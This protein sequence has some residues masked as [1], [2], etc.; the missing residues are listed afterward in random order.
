MLFSI[1]IKVIV[2]RMLVIVRF[3]NTVGSETLAYGP[4][5][6][7]VIPGKHPLNGNEIPAWLVIFN[8]SNVKIIFE[9]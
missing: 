3:K 8:K 6:A 5:I 7:T 1:K 9:Y 2:V 4:L